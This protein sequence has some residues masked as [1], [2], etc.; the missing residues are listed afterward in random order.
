MVV[1]TQNA[2]YT[3]WFTV[4]V[5][6]I[7]TPDKD[8]LRF[9]AANAFTTGSYMK[10]CDPLTG[11]CYNYEIPVAETA[12]IIGSAHIDFD[13]VADNTY[14]FEIGSRNRIT[15]E[16]VGATPTLKVE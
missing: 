11:D 7:T 6:G 8:A 4:T 10:V 16:D 5:A 14:Y 2:V 1:A 13:I 3:G 12:A 9:T 15:M